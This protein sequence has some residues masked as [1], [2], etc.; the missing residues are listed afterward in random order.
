MTSLRFAVAV[1]LVVLPSPA[2]QM[3]NIDLTPLSFQDNSTVCGKQYLAARNATYQCVKTAWEEAY[4]NTINN[5]QYTDMICS[6]CSNN[7]N[8]MISNCTT[9]PPSTPDIIARIKAVEILLKAVCVMHRSAKLALGLGIFGGVLALCCCCLCL[10][11][12]AACLGLC[13]GSKKRGGRD[14]EIGD[15]DGDDMYEE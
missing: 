11:G 7:F 14:A 3:P 6:T 13:G 2:A 10:A 1:F 4:N 15:A 8:N 9:D 12:L 5:K